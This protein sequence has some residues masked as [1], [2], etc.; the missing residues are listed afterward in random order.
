MSDRKHKQHHKKQR[1]Q[2]ENRSKSRSSSSSSSDSDSECGDFEELYCYMKRHLLEDPALMIA[3][4]NAYV[5]LY[6][7]DT[8]QK[9]P[10]NGPL[11][12]SLFGPVQNVDHP[13]PNGPVYVRESGTYLIAYSIETDQPCQFAIY[14]NGILK[15]DTVLG[16]NSGSGQIVSR[17]I[18]QLEKDDNVIVRNHTSS[19]LSGSVEV[20]QFAGGTAPQANVQFVLTKI[21][22][23]KKYW[24]QTDN[25]RHNK[26]HD[27]RKELYCKLERKLL[28][29]PE[30]QL[31][32]VDAYGMFFTQSPQTVSIGGS[33]LFD[34]CTDT[35]CIRHVSGSG[36]VLIEKNGVY[37]VYAMIATIK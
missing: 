28:C 18:L 2:G 25:L 21:A 16:T 10:I 30:L 37:N 17:Q 7:T 24:C 14:V 35:Q 33:V 3:G 36:D 19:V 20:I 26:D 22:P 6:N 29:D 5:N 13:T 31:E 11:T 4:S 15:P 32:G 27:K 8:I 9:I 1:S 12:E 23:H 34:K